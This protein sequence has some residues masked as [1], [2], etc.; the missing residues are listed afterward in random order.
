MW[1]FMPPAVHDR[2]MSLLPIKSP[3]IAVGAV[4]WDDAGRC[5]LI[6]RGRPP[7][8][9]EW[10]IP[11]GKI[12]W[13]ETLHD[14]IRREVR[15]ETGLTIA[16]LGRIDVVDSI[17]ADTDGEVA[18][19]HVLIDFSARVVSG[20]LK[21]MDDVTEARAVELGE[22]ANYEM[23]DETRRVITLSHAKHLAT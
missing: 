10:S 23:W 15:E 1:R 9:N 13:G 22:L 7:R 12:H 11:G 16:I 3:I 18:H 5:I 14:A 6:R 2:I 8:L 21:A 4:V 19:H 17:I 20:A